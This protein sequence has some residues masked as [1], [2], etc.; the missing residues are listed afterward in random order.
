MALMM[1]NGMNFSIGWLMEDGSASM[2]SGRT[3][4]APT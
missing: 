3:R 2:M 4:I 1:T